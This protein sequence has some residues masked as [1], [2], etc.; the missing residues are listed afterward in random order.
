MNKIYDDGKTVIHD[1]RK[2][3]SVEEAFNILCNGGQVLISDIPDFSEDE[4]DYG[5]EYL[6]NLHD[7]VGEDVKAQVCEEV[8]QYLR[9][10]EV[11]SNDR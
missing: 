1:D 8:Y 4:P 2:R 9:C 3:L 5:H 11:F 7:I 6:I 10:Y